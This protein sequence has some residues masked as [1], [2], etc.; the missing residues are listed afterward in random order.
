MLPLENVRDLK[1]KHTKEAARISSMNAQ[2]AN[3]S[4]QIQSIQQVQ[5]RQMIPF[6][7]SLIIFWLKN[8]EGEPRYELG[9]SVRQTGEK[10]A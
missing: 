6:F 5:T 7:F 10:W 4:T 8:R 1:P 9:R 2:I 3:L